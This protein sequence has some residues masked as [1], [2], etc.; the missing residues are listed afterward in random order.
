MKEKR[1]LKYSV[2]QSRNENEL[3][4]MVSVLKRYWVGVG[5]YRIGIKG[6]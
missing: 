6:K 1:M 3:R 5:Q 4:N 2:G